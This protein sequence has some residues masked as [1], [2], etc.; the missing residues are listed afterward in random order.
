M[1]NFKDVR[2]TQE[3]VP[4]IEVNKDTAYIRTNIVRIATEEFTGWEYDEIQ[5]DKD[6]YIEFMANK[7]NTQEPLVERVKTATEIYEEN[8]DKSELLIDDLKTLRI[9]KLKE[10]CSNAI[11]AGFTVNG[12]HFGMNEHDQQNLTQQLLLVVAGQTDSIQW[13]T[14][15]VGVVE[16]TTLQFKAVA[17]SAKNHKMA[18]QLKYWTLE[19]Q[20]LAASD[21]ETIKLIVWA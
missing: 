18:E 5:Y 2:G 21:K 8:K 3:N 13:K 7:Q 12:A 6:E 14:K 10:E 17:E 11:Y 9:G 15:N 19:Q 1:Y 4:E 20:I 16:L